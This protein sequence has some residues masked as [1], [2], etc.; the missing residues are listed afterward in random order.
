MWISLHCEFLIKRNLTPS[1][2]ATLGYFHW[3]GGSP[4]QPKVLSCGGLSNDLANLIEQLANIRGEMLA[5]EKEFSQ[6]ISYVHSV[7]AIVREICCTIWH[8]DVTTCDSC[9]PN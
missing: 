1:G 9:R 3:R 7:S 5:L 4:M 6:E 8:C 2:G